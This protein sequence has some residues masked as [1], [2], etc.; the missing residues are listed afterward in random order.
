MATP[1]SWNVVVRLGNSFGARTAWNGRV[2][3]GRS[4]LGGETYRLSGGL[5]VRPSARFQLSAT[6]NYLRAINP[7]QYVTTFDSGG[8]VATYGGRYVFGLV[9]QSTFLVQL[10]VN[11]TIAPDLT[12]YG[13]ALA[14]ANHHI[15]HGS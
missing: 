5:S 8:P 6:P 2:Y 1:E 4:A 7:R 3:Y 11:Y 15:R 13:I 9:D 12:L 10:R 14:Y